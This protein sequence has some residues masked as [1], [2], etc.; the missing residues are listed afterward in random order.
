MVFH[1]TRRKWVFYLRMMR[2]MF[3]VKRKKLRE[4]WGEFNNAELHDLYAST[5]LLG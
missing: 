4:G 3:G 2:K 1:I 5:L